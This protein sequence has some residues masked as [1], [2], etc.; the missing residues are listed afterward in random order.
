MDDKKRSFDD[1][2]S[3]ADLANKYLG[4]RAP[5]ASDEKNAETSPV[6]PPVPNR[7]QPKNEVYFSNQYH[8]AEYDKAPARQE[9]TAPPALER[10]NAYPAAPLAKKENTAHPGTDPAEKPYRKRRSKSRESLKKKKGKLRLKFDATRF[11]KNTY[12]FF[13]AVISLSVIISVYTVFCINDV[14][15][16]TK[17]KDAV[18][19]TVSEDDVKNVNSV[20]NVLRENKLINCPL[21]CKLFVRVRSDM[22]VKTRKGP[23]EYTQ[24]TFVLNPKMGLEGLLVTLQGEVAEKETV[25]LTFPEG[26]TIPQV[27]QKLVDNNVC[28]ENALK[29]ELEKASFTYS[30]LNGI[31]DNEKI[32]YKFEGYLFPDTYEFYEGENPSS[33]LEKFVKALDEKITQELRQR[34]QDIGMSI[35]QVL[36]LA[37]IIQQEAAN[38]EQ[39]KTIS[40]ILHNRLNNPQLFPMLECN[41][42]EDY[43][44]NKVAGSLTAASPHTADYYKNY[45]NTYAVLGLPPGPICNPG[46]DAIE[47]ALNPQKTDLFYFCHDKAGKMY[48]AKTLDEQNAN[49]SKYKVN[50]AG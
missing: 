20:I 33:V 29:S 46:M 47:A 7:A 25:R 3:F 2:A 1:A 30:I 41:S 32:P 19:V 49:I 18:S 43:I 9:P 4:D 37:S 40:S 42:T 26:Y 8:P 24:G 36:T 10:K 22:F 45:Y 6:L 27:I 35:P 48:T 5:Q 13:A 11:T 44:K 28:D 23:I 21:F 15:A 34:A 38:K 31:T 17:N 39:M 16:L 12:I 14:L 50:T